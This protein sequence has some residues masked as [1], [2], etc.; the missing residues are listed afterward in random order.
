MSDEDFPMISQASDALE[1]VQTPQKEVR[2]NPPEPRRNPTTE[3]RTAPVSAAADPRKAS[4][5]RRP[6]TVVPVKP[7]SSEASGNRPAVQ[8]PIARPVVERAPAADDEDPE[9]LLREYADRQKTKVLRLE[10]QLTE[11]RK[12]VAERDGLRAKVDALGRELQDAKRQLEAAGKSDEIIKDLQ[13]KVDAAILSNSILADDKEKLKKALSTQTENLKK[14]EE[15]AVQAEKSLAEQQKQ[16]AEQK[17]G[18]EAA[19]SRVAAALEALQA[20]APAPAKA[21]PEKPVSEMAT[22]PIEAAP[23]RAAAE[24][25]AE[26][27]PAPP[28]PP[29]GRPGAPPG[30]FS[31]LKK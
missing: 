3:I 31:F 23:A 6:G 25:K 18:R 8:A 12:V 5:L 27:R 24:E 16:L 15:R 28:K 26:A 11:Y 7:A 20:D 22:R 17:S 19:E 4:E 29:A 9:K 13:G 1:P 2:V 30:R 10:Q 21:A 14:S